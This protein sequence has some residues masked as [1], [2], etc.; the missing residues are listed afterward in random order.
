M[1]APTVKLAPPVWILAS[2][3]GKMAAL[4]EFLAPPKIKVAVGMG[5]YN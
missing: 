4:L 2:H 1:A 5:W 3:N